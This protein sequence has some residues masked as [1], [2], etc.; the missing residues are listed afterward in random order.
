MKYII[1]LIVVQV[2]FIGYGHL[3]S[4][5]LNE[6]LFGNRARYA[7]VGENKAGGDEFVFHFYKY[8]SDRLD[9][10][11]FKQVNPGLRLIIPD[12]ISI[13]PPKFGVVKDTVYAVGYLWNKNNPKKNLL[14]LLLVANYDT[15]HPSYYFDYNL[16]LDYSNDGAPLKF[17]SDKKVKRIHLKS[18]LTGKKYSFD[19]INPYFQSDVDSVNQYV[20]EESGVKEAIND[21]NKDQELVSRNEGLEIRKFNNGRLQFFVSLANGIGSIKYDYDNTTTGFHTNYRVSMNSKGINLG[22]GYKLG[23]LN[24]HATGGVENYYFWTSVKETKLAPVEKCVTA[25]GVIL[26]CYWDDVYERTFNQDRH[27]KNRFSLGIDL[28]YDIQV[29]QKLGLAPYYRWKLYSFDNQNQYLPNRHQESAFL[30]T[31]RNLIEFGGSVKGIV[32]PRSLLFLFLGYSIAS[33]NPEDYF[34]SLPVE[35]V[36]TINSQLNIEL[37]WQLSL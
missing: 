32:S 4:Q 18:E 8:T 22:F 36:R 29:S 5:D 28:S 10:R 35:N 3:Y 27:P 9:L 1:N 20:V 24:I 34:E 12:F 33:F 25:G 23:N 30:L 26:Y 17:V 37:G 19:L 15:Y 6:Y 2:T 13:A 16:D 11:H 21:I 31:N 7:N 14:L